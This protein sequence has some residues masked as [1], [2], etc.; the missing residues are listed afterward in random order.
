MANLIKEDF[1]R[2]WV[3]VQRFSHDRT[4]CRVGRHGVGEELRVLHLSLKREM[5]LGLTCTS[6]SSMPTPVTHFLQ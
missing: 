2:G 6:E 3:R 1:E 5:T 4:W